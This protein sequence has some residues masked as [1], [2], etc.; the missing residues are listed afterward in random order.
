[1]W[2]AIVGTALRSPLTTV[3][4]ITRAQA[5]AVTNAHHNPAKY[6]TA[7]GPRSTPSNGTQPRHDQSS[8]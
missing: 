3:T 2:L 6:A 5:H 7:L 8:G 4:T 1:M